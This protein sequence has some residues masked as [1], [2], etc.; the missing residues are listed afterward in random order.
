MTVG[1][2][3]GKDATNSNYKHHFFSSK[4]ADWQENNSTV[5]YNKFYS[6]NKSG[7]RVVVNTV[8]EVS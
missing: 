1:H 7:S 4:E 8:P 6:L 3:P 2:T 5:K